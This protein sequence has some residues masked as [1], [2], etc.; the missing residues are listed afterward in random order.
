MKEN[1]LRMLVIVVIYDAI[2]KKTDEVTEKLLHIWNL[3]GMVLS[4]IFLC[5]MYYLD[6]LSFTKYMV[7]VRAI[8]IL[9]QLSSDTMTFSYH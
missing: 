7:L 5:V 9:F 4:T 3:Y 8:T 6:V 1:S 2:M